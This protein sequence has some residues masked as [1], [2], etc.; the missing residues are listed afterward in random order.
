MPSTLLHCRYKVLGWHL[1]EILRL[2][3]GWSLGVSSMYKHNMKNPLHHKI[4]LIS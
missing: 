3:L 1:G 4:A 2:G